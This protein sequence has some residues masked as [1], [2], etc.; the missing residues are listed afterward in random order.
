MT[1]MIQ[2][3]P[4]QLERWAK[5]KTVDYNRILVPPYV[6]SNAFLWLNVNII[7][8]IVLSQMLLEYMV[9]MLIYITF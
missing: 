7:E 4:Q 3:E 1:K 2:K 5:I 9:Y 8:Y 6:N